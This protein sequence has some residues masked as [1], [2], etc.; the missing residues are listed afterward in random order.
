MYKKKHKKISEKKLLADLMEFDEDLIEDIDYLQ[1]YVELH[2]SVELGKVDIALYAKIRLAACNDREHLKGDYCIR[3]LQFF[4][5]NRELKNTL[6]GKVDRNTMGKKFKASEGLIKSVFRNQKS[7]ELSVNT[8]CLIAG[9]SKNK[10]YRII[11]QD[12][13]DIKTIQYLKSI[14]KEIE[15]E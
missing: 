15:N 14:Q 13:E 5:E 10:Y 2:Q 3:L 6:V 1:W 12:V 9:I 4:F 11:N 7:K 8:F